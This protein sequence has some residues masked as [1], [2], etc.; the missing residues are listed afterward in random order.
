MRSLSD[1]IQLCLQQPFQVPLQGALCRSNLP[2]QAVK[3]ISANYSYAQSGFISMNSN[4]F[5]PQPQPGHLPHR[6]AELRQ[7]LRHFNPTT[8]AVR[9]QAVYIS[10]GEGLGE[11]RLPLWGREVR[12]TWPDL[13][14][15]DPDSGHELSVDQQA[16]VVYYFYTCD[17]TPLAG[18]WIS[19]SELP[20]GGFYVRAFQ[21][22]SGDELARHFA[23]DTARFEQAALAAG[24]YPVTFADLAFAFPLLPR[25]SLL[26]AYWA[27]DEDFP[28]SMR[29]L[30]D[31]AA[32]HHL[33]MDVCAIAGGMLTRRI[34]KTAR[35]MQ[36]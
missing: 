31:A 32:E 19:F 21:G 24:G 36:P 8:F 3:F 17:G 18:R 35:S 33:P 15:H 2:A 27:S 7:Q 28:A 14:A 16:L 5:S 1:D 6:V 12:L 30:F 20:G 34:L 29:V 4:T 10:T 13:I 11:F 9:T 26:V 23:D 25:L 22:Y